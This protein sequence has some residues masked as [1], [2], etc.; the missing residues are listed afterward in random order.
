M[1]PLSTQTFT[2]DAADQSGTFHSDAS[3]VTSA[4]ASGATTFTVS[5]NATTQS[6]TVSTTGRTQTFAPADQVASGSTDF[7]AFQKSSGTL[8]ESLSLTVPGTTGALQYQYVGGG[9]WERATNNG[10]TLD[11]TYNPF[12]YGIVTPDANLA[13]SG[14][15]FYAVSL[16]GARQTELPYAMAGS[17]SLQISFGSGQ[18]AASG[19]LTTIDVGTGFIKSLGIFYGAAQLSSSTNAFSGTFSMDDG[20]RFTGGWQGRFYGPANQEVG[21]VWYISSAGGEYG[22]GYLVGRSDNSVTPHNFSLSPLQFTEDFPERFAE[23]TFHDNGDGT[24]TSGSSMLRSDGT[25]T[26]NAGASSFNYADTAA[27]INS[28]FPG[29]SLNAAASNSSKAVYEITNSGTTYRLTLGKAGTGNPQIA[30]NYVSFGNWQQLQNGSTNARDRWFAWGVRSNAFQIPTGTGHFDGIVVGKAATVD[31]GSL[32]S[33]GGTSSFDV[34]F[35]AATF[36]GSIHPI[37]TD[38]KTLAS[39]DFGTFTTTGGVMDVD[40]GLTADFYDGSSHYLGFFEGALYGPH[41]EEIG[42]SFGLVNGQFAPWDAGY[43]TRANLTGAVIG[44]R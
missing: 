36:N 11:F 18:I 28:T 21:A 4:H 17:G 3:P 19:V 6:Y 14:N 5:Y 10:S 24:A 1:G 22:A 43:A 7:K 27:G 13:R 31:G 25:L 34:N 41:A 16:V 8:T 26:F 9:A 39:R 29:A 20:S 23:L 12:T 44:K 40:G 30:L 35:S 15:G 42:G 33:L 37:G 32:Y 38:L 2:N